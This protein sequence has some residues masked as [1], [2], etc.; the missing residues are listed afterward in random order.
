MFQIENSIYRVKTKSQNLIRFCGLKQKNPF[1]PIFD[2]PIW[3]NSIDKNLID[4]V[5]VIVKE[6]EKDFSNTKWTDYNF[7]EWSQH[8]VQKIKEQIKFNINCFLQE[9]NVPIPSNL[10]INGWIFPQKKNMNLKLHNHATHENSFL[11]GNIVLTHN[12]TT[13]NYEIPFIS[14][15][16]GLFKVKNHQGAITLF[17]SYLPHCVDSLSD[18]ERYSI[19]FDIITEDGMNCFLKNN[20]DKNNCL[21]RSVKL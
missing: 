7:F 10:W 20:N 18:E 6:N 11:S 13:T 17:P 9:L 1:A 8:E 16:E 12:C 14:L 19:G 4:K 15:N 2:V 3:M 21:I 5:L